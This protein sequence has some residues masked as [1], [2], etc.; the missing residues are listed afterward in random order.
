MNFTEFKEINRIIQNNRAEKADLY[1]STHNADAIPIR[2][3]DTIR[4]HKDETGKILDYEEILYDSPTRAHPTSSP[5]IKDKD[6][7]PGSSESKDES[8]DDLLH[9]VNELYKQKIL[10]EKRVSHKKGASMRMLHKKNSRE[11]IYMEQINLFQRRKSNPEISNP[12]ERRSEIR[13]MTSFGKIDENSLEDSSR[14]RYESSLS[15]SLNKLKFS[16]NV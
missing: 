11:R 7:S 12:V 10:L 1:L 5:F 8:I 3:N 14:R 16:R 15:K 2:H 6:T 9:N 4:S 13:K